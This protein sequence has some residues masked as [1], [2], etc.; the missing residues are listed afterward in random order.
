MLSTFNAWVATPLMAL[1]FLVFGFFFALRMKRSE[2][3]YLRFL[4][5][6]ILGIAAI[7]LIEFLFSV[8]SGT[9][10][11][12][13]AEASWDY[14]QTIFKFCFFLAIYAWTFLV[15][16]LSY[17]GKASAIY[18]LCAIS[19]TAQHLSHNLI[20]LIHIFS[21]YIEDPVGRE[22]FTILIREG[23]MLLMMA[24]ALIFNLKYGEGVNPYEGNTK[25]KV[26]SST[27]VVLVCI[28][29]YR[30]N[31]DL[32]AENVLTQLGMSL[33]ALTSCALL[34]LLFFGL[35]ESDK[36]H[37]EAETYREL[38]HQQKE[39]YELSK[40]TI[41]LINMK[42]H[43]LKHQ[44][45]ALR[46]SDNEAYV[47]ELE[48]D[49]MIF[50]ASIKTGNE[51]LD[52][53]LR[54]KMLE[55]ESEGITLTCFID[56][57]AISFMSEMDIYSL[58]GNIL[59]NAFESVKRL[60]EKQKRTIALSGRTL[61]NMFFLHEE[62]FVGAPLE[63]VDGLPKTTKEDVDNHGFGMKSMRRIAEKYQGEMVV[64]N[65]GETFSVDF[66]FTLD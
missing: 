18:L 61:G 43:D 29:L 63:F 34:L 26:A 20:S 42:C 6:G 33:Y 22:W 40:S 30:L 7:F 51:V 10:F 48:H 50:D 1:E 52:V 31:S 17:Q 44:L 32:P 11:H 3:F 25:R 27:V 16:R 62:N 28:G 56:G 5:F 47:K 38:L 46:T 24:L 64:K 37:A 60:E 54:E 49:I 19:F 21:I 9:E 41:D 8:I 13:G 14:R 53:L 39:Q 23:V 57:K 35:W 66:V 15:F 2:Y 4:S 58:F 12:Y 45:R 55:A 36:T 65:E 59:S